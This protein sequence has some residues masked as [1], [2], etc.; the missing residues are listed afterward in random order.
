MLKYLRKRSLLTQVELGRAVGYSREQINH[1]ESG[2]RNPDPTTIAALFIPALDLEHNVELASRLLTLAEA[3]RTAS[4]GNT[5]EA[6]ASIPL[7]AADH[8]VEAA[9]RSAH[10]LA[11]EAAELAQGDILE[12]AQQ[13]FL[14]DEF[15][16]AADVLFDQGPYLSSQGRAHEAIEVLDRILAAVR[17]SET[18]SDQGDSIRRLLTT[19]GDL[20]LNTA[21]AD[22]AEGNYRE[23]LALTSGAVRTT[24][25]YRLALS[26]T[27]RGHASEALAMV[28]EAYVDLPPQH[29]LIGAQLKI[30]ECS[31]LLALARFHEAEGAGLEALTIAEQIAVAMPIMVAGIRARAHN[32]LGT[33]NAI[34]HHPA[35]ALEHWKQAVETAHMTGLRSLEYRCQGNIANVLYEIGDLIGAMTACEAAIDGLR[36]V[37]DLHGMAHFIHL[38]ANLCYIRGDVEASLAFA[39]EACAVK[40]QLG[41][42]RSLLVSIGQQIK[43]LIGLDRVAEASAMLDQGITD[44]EA[45]GDDRLHGYWLM[46]SC[47]L[48]LLSGDYRRARKAVNTA[49]ALPSTSDEAKLEGDCTNHLAMVNLAGGDIDHAANLLSS[50]EPIGIPE[51]DLERE[52]IQW[53]V[54][55]ARGDVQMIIDGATA[56]ASRARAQGYLIY[57][58]RA[59][60]LLQALSD[61]AMSSLPFSAFPA[62]VYGKVS[63]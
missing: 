16:A 28:Q 18:V 60:R 7:A 62:L 29:L 26:L 45:I 55:R 61:P 20:V 4:A 37:D 2:R 42:R 58:L 48:S 23:A 25:I 6:T 21:Q 34:H 63:G 10:H 13:Y 32:V 3:T 17:K 27:Q 11:A 12:A 38:R 43:S 8:S 49:M 22:E 52:L 30:V 50:S 19:R 59:N 51:I 31:A 47:E 53:L 56:T 1:L 46:L 41:E 35:V 40:R 57:E 9:A 5:A 39:E 15:K 44:V 54:D 14:A 24:L 36:A 33:I